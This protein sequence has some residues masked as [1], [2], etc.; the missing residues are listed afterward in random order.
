MKGLRRWAAV[1]VAC[2]LALPAGADEIPRAAPEAVGMSGPRLAKVA[3][4]VQKMVDDGKIAGAI[5][6][7]AR[8]GRIVHFETYGLRDLDE[9]K[10]V[11][12]D[13]IMRFYSMS[14]P[15]TTAAA[16]TLYDEGKLRLDEPVETYVPELKGLKVYRDDGPVEPDRKVTVRDLMSHTS[17]FTYGIFGN[18]PV[19]Q[20]YRQKRILGSRDLESMVRKLGTIPLMYQPGTRWHY[21][22]STDVLGCL[23]EK[24]AGKKLDAFLRERIFEP[25][26]MRDTAFFVPQARV[27]RFSSC[28]APAPDG[29][30]LMEKYSASRYLA[31]PTF[32][33]GGGGLVSTARD[34][35]RFCQMLTRRGELFGTR[36]L[37]AE[38][39][40]MMTKNQL[41]E[42]VHWGGNNGFG[43]GFSVRLQGDGSAAH[44][45]EYGWG[46]AAGT[47]FW[48]SP[49]DGLAVVA[50]SQLMPFSPQLQNAVKPLVYEAIQD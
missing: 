45:G 49:D 18:S 34:Y 21:G 22:V 39:V 4:A 31:A 19:D 2:M 46:G 30:A 8:K 16:M 32:L 20:I 14:K 12:E 41:P 35:M 15:I 43:L 6:M 29:P 3:S 28:Y 47:H 5:T 38:T 26:D 36:V 17:G 10:P 33:S 1:A 42:G 37:K 44:A 23:V 9:K 25:L 27:D 24:V 50:L 11:T 48:I 40:D 7:V 13:T